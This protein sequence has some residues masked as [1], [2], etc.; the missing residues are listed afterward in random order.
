MDVYQQYI[1]KSR[2]SRYIDSKKRREN[3]GESVDRYFDFIKK[4]LLEK[5]GYTHDEVEIKKLSDYVKNLQVMPSMRAIMSAGKALERDNT[6]GFNCSFIPV[7]DPKAFDEALH[8]LSCGTGVGFSVESRFTE[9]LPE[10]PHKIY[11][12]E[13]VIVV[14]DSKEGW[15]KA[16][17]Q[18]IALLYSGEAP[19][20]DVSKV[21]PA[22]ARLKT[23][24]GRASGPEPLVE[25][26]NFVIKI[27]KS[28]T[29]RKLKP[30]ECHDI[31]CKIAEVIVV[32]G[33]RRCLPEGTKVHTPNGFK[34]IELLKVGD[35][36]DTP[37]GAKRVANV[38]DQGVQ[39]T[40]VIRH[41]FGE[42]ECTPNHKMAVFDSF[43][44]WTFK[45]ARELTEN[46]RLV[47]SPKEVVYS[48]KIKMPEVVCKKSE[49]DHVSTD[50]VTPDL[51]E[52]LAWFLG[53]FAGDGYVSLSKR[54]GNKGYK[55]N[56]SIAVGNGKEEYKE[57]I[58]KAISLFGDLNITDEKSKGKYSVIRVTSIHL[59]KW[60]HENIKKPNEKISIPDF[61][62]TSDIDIRWAYLAGIIDSDGS[63]TAKQPTLCTTIYK[64]FSD[65][66]L[67]LY[68]SLGVLAYANEKIRRQENWRNIYSVKTKGYHNFK[69]LENGF[70]NKS[71]S[72]NYVSTKDVDGY[73]FPKTFEVKSKL[74]T[75][76]A[77]SKNITARLVEDVRKEPLSHYPVK[78]LGL[79]EK[80]S[81]QTW[82]IEVEDVHQFIAENFVTHNSALISLSD[83]ED[84]LIREAKSGSWWNHNGQRALANNSA[85]YD[86]KPSMSQFMKE[87]TSLYLSFSGER[88]MFSRYASKM[89][90]S[91]SGR[92]N[93]DYDFGTNPCSE[94]I[95]RPYQFCN[96]TSIVV[97][98]DDDLGALKEK[99]R[100][101][102]VLGTFQST[103]THFPYLRKIWQK[104]TEEERLLGVSLTGLCDHPI[105]SDPSDDSAEWLKQMK[106]VVI[107]TNKDVAAKIGV[108]QSTATTCVKPEGTASQLN[109]SASGMHPRYAQYY[110]RRVRNDKKD[111]LTKFLI[112]QGIP[113]EDDVMNP[114]TVVFSF[115]R[116]SPAGS[117][118][119]DDKT[120]IEQLEFWAHLQDNW[121]EHK[122][123]V[124]VYVKDH[125]W[126]DVG[127]WV[128]KNF[129][130]ISGVS[131]LP[132]DGGTY[133]Q[134]P[135][136]EITED[137]Y[138]EMVK[139]IPENI[140]WDS[141]VES[142]DNV[143]GVQTLSCSAGVC[144]I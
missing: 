7:D 20:Y 58:K 73:S 70:K 101:A 94:I 31:M 144:E 108:Q 65:D 107:E 10:V 43:D 81:V 99:A 57:K 6:A 68:S 30:I 66:I 60:L 33:V 140:D 72:Y 111:P 136:E 49:R 142:D 61:I 96:L 129:D 45:E 125:E 21:R 26:F 84:D 80:R 29:G 28:A 55:G 15:A 11:D 116:K 117:K 89:I 50:V 13:T 59:A 3:Y 39:D 138:N 37:Y 120:A 1:A 95:L 135:Y 16:L 130:K 69:A 14:R 85:V 91:L 40:I 90:S 41:S 114:S 100:L 88:G 64:S 143:E 32:G 53:Y 52:L 4:H 46:D 123:S 124:T 115:P 51:N 22:G 34:P 24:G 103:L 112:D 75:L 23:F 134:A 8:I 97:R 110:I 56:I 106:D 141:L 79:S 35:F 104:N 118:M 5:H 139:L 12:S 137:Q 48:E 82:D 127:A 9:K 18:L 71:L 102:A 76:S 132:H 54:P 42:F 119:R 87:W 27:F 128:Y 83:L 25:L 126:M 78:I 133:R 63:C 113:C 19:K 92:R 105:L 67:E 74:K 93:I 2:Y 121:C 44:T 36:V 109:D 122:P 38:F 131:F 77:S 17:R 47:M 86:S 98:P 62:K